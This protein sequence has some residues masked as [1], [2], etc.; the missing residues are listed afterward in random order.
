MALDCLGDRGMPN[1]NAQAPTAS[2]RNESALI[3]VAVCTYNRHGM[4]RRLLPAIERQSLSRNQF[5]VLIVDNSDDETARDAF[6]RE[7]AQNQ[8]IDVV[9]TSPPGLSRARNK[10]ME[11]C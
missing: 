11:L 9:Y 8:S 7:M 2:A 6:A 4:V 1:S 5:H 10:A 3:T